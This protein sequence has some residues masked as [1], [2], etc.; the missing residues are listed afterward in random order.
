MKRQVFLKKWCHVSGGFFRSSISKSTCL[1]LGKDYIFQLVL[2]KEENS[3]SDFI[4]FSLL[5]AHSSNSSNV[6][7][8]VGGRV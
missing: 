7:C 3:G 8:S 1:Q 4:P 2:G 6:I 5:I